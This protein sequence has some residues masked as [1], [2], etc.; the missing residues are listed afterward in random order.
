MEQFI[1]CDARRKFSV[2]GAVNEKGQ[3]GE[4]LRVAHNRQVHREFLG[5]LPAHSA[6]VVEASDRRE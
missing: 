2:F 4:A 1:G 3:A 5:R 6:I